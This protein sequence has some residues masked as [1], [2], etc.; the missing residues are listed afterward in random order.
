MESII[1]EHKASVIR[2]YPME[3]LV[4]LLCMSV[5]FLSWHQMKT[6]DKLDSLQGE[7]KGYLHDDR[8]TLIK[9]IDKNT[10]VMQDV[11]AYLQSTKK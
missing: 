6:D 8:Q 11:K 4:A 9:S 3:I 5:T 2:K 10:D 7:M 1:N